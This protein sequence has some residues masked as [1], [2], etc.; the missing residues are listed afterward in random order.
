MI[1]SLE[2][3]MPLGDRIREARRRADLSQEAL[4]SKADVTVS[5][6]RKIEQGSVPNPQWLTI[7]SITR[8]LGMSLDELSDKQDE[9]PAKNLPDVGRRK[10]K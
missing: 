1:A 6:L 5:A 10:R 4:A 8:A 9:P 3:R 7:R 2:I